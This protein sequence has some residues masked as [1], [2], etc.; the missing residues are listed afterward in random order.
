MNQD[1]T[2]VLG[3]HDEEIERLGLQHSVWR[4][5]A[6][7]AWQRAGF[8]RG[9][10][11]V[12]L[13]CG[14]GWATLD[15]AQLVGPEG[16]VIAIDRSRRFLDALEA[17]AAALGLRNIET[18]EIDLG[19]GPLPSVQAHGLWTRW[20]YSFVAQPR[21][22]ANRAAAMLAPGGTMVVHEYADYNSW[23]WSHPC[24]AFTRFVAAVMAS[25]R[26]GGGEPDIARVLPQ[27]LLEA[28][29]ALQ[30]LAPHTFVARPGD[31][32][33]RWPEAFI[34]AGSRQLVALEF[35]DEAARDA[36][37]AAYAEFVMK[38]GAY[39]LTPLVLE[40]IARRT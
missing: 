2:Y 12:D 39:Q 36:L 15:L 24:D 23:Q 34:R 7:A 4:P 38:P 29:L 20:V 8:D 6:T 31:H 19:S 16:R 35:L 25:W 27:W 32:A 28:G 17:R 40:V 11:I 26:A 9:Q 22:L 33:W 30:S 37:L 5:R 18:H 14:P 3:T 10:T 1:K 21:D 13:G